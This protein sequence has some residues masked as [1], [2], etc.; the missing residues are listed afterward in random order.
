M[1]CYFKPN[2][3]PKC[4]DEI[5][6]GTITPLTDADI[7]V[8]YSSGKAVKHSVT[9]DALGELSFSP[10]MLESKQELHVI[11]SGKFI[12]DYLSVTIGAETLSSPIH[13]ES[14]PVFDT[15]NEPIT[16]ASVTLSI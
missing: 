4:V 9:S 11:E 10:I 12:G 3:I 15:L 2:P 13:L 16:Y 5:V 14:I 7:I 8:R 6:I 1:S